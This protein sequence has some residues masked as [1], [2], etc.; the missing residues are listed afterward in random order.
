MT[1][2][3]TRQGVV[4]ALLTALVVIAVAWVARAGPAAALA[5]AIAAL[6]VDAAAS[7]IRPLERRIA[8]GY[9]RAADRKLAR[10]RPRVI[11]ITGSYGKTTVK[12]HVRDLLGSTFDTLATPAS[13]NNLAGLARAINEQLTPATEVFVA[14]MGTYG[15]GEIA[16]M[17]RWLR[18]E[19][20]VITAIG[21][22]HLERMRTIETVVAAKSEI[23]EGVRAAVVCVDSP[24][25]AQLAADLRR[26]GRPP[27]VWTVSGDPR[28]ADADVVVAE[29][30]MRAGDRE[31]AVLVIR[32]RGERVGEVARGSLHAGNVACAVGAALAIGVDTRALSGALSGLTAATSRA[33]VAVGANGVTVVDDTFNANPA[34]AAAA[35]ETLTRAVPQGRR[36]VVSPGMIELGPL[37]FEANRQFAASVAATGADLVVVG[38]TNRAALL[39]GHPGAVAVRDR[40][41]ARR[42]V[43][44]HLTSGDGVLWENDLPDHYP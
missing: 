29:E 12:Q 18:P 39:A 20:G 25:L 31:P 38:W 6:A 28:H 21:P 19:V 5:P 16:A 15:P 4:A 11:A 9:R 7:L 37:Q 34:G 42:W 22:V 32:V 35:L 14:E 17:A 36:A 26:A 43:R 44:A 1:R 24:P 41:A 8:R 40:E 3:A 2:R 27:E 30:C 13:W 23:L 10:T 33:A